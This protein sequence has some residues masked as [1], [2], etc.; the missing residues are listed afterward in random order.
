VAA[1]LFGLLIWILADNGGALCQI[2]RR[3]LDEGSDLWR[4]RIALAIDEVFF[5]ERR[6]EMQD[7]FQRLTSRYPELD[8][9]C[10]RRLAAWD[11][12]GYPGN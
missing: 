12:A 5:Y 4:L 10:K 6:S 2:I 8:A 9:A 7:A 1:E 11:A 3:W